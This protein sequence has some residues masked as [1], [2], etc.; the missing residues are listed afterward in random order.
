MS[1]DD[2]LDAQ[3]AAE[4]QHVDVDVTLNKA[5]RTIRVFAM[6]GLDWAAATD[7]FP[8]RPDV[9]LDSVYGY[10]L[11]P[12]SKYLAPLCAKLLEDGKP[13]DLTVEQV[14]KLFKALPGNQIMQLGD[15]MWTLNEYLP[16][17][18]VKALKKG[19]AAKSARNSKQPTS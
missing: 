12:L 13:V 10:N 3:I 7:M 16:G 15:A 9:P 8:A 2:D 11:R 18:A 1:F 17:E 19:S 5:L 6:D 4:T 14:D